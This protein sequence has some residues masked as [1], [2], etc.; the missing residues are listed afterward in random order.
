[1]SVQRIALRTSRQ[2]FCA[3]DFMHSITKSTFN[4][5]ILLHLKEHIDVSTP[6]EFHL[7]SHA[8]LWSGT[9]VETNDAIYQ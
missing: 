3:L 9:E 2:N 5:R 6:R 1:M 7:E 8:V 4:R